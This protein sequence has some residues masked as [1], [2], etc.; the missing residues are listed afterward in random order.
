MTIGEALAAN[1]AVYQREA[2]ASSGEK[3]PLPASP[4]LWEEEVLEAASPQAPEP[5]AVYRLETGPLFSAFSREGA[6]SPTA[7]E[8]GLLERL[9]R[10][11]EREN[12][13]TSQPLTDD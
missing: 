6:A 4:S 2:T 11:I 5:A 7:E 3:L 8:D 10:R 12:R 13:L 1:R 9:I